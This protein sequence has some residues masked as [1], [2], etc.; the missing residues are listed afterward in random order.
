MLALAL[1]A[2]F[3]WATAAVV[4]QTIA[5]IGGKPLYSVTFAI[6]ADSTDGT[7]T[8][9]AISA[10]SLNVLKGLF[11]YSADWIP[12]GVTVPTDGTSFTVENALGVDLLGAAGGGRS[13]TV[14]QTVTPASGAHVVDGTFSLKVSGN[15][16]N[17]ATATIVLYFASS[18]SNSSGSFGGSVSVINLPTDSAHDAIYSEAPIGTG[19]Y[20]VTVAPAVVAAG[21]KVHDLGTLEG[22]QITYPLAPPGD[23]FQNN[24]EI[25][26]TTWATILAGASGYY[27]C[28]TSITVTNGDAA[29]MTDVFVYEDD[30]GDIA[31]AHM[32]YQGHAGIAGGGFGAGNGSG[33]IAC[34]VNHS[35][36]GLYI[37]A[38]TTSA[39]LHWN[40]R[41]FRTKVLQVIAP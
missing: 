10:G 37:V 12:G 4:T 26:D 11:L 19:K 33:T 8:D 21:D 1:C 22:A 9:T 25:T 31:D 28:I 14:A 39:E 13:A 23:W 5:Q 7:V 35:G 16:V 41:G 24:G 20:A 40:V 36:Y 32:I 34:G 18:A 27:Y 30:D 2:Q 15:G 38:E 17:S 29:A 3:L 6:T